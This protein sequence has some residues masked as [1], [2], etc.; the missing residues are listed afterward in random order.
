MANPV[1]I[2]WLI[3]LSPNHARDQ[4]GGQLPSNLCKAE[5]DCWIWRRDVLLS[6]WVDWNHLGILEVRREKFRHGEQ[7]EAGALP[8][9]SPSFLTP[10][11][12]WNDPPIEMDWSWKSN[13]VTPTGKLNTVMNKIER[14]HS[15]E[16]SNGP[17]IEMGWKPGNHVL[18]GS[19]RLFS[20]IPWPR[21]MIGASDKLICQVTP[22][23]WRKTGNRQHNSHLCLKSSQIIW[24]LLDLHTRIFGFSPEIWRKTRNRSTAEQPSLSKI[25]SNLEIF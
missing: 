23:I 25:I 15:T 1:E 18:K 3:T 20:S 4:F 14:L 11:E 21:E 22:E 2:Q 10:T 6:S 13:R 19:G 24:N 8:S 7:P 17:P 16:G 5:S 12:A 9:H